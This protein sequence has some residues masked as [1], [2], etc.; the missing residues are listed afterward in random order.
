MGGISIVLTVAIFGSEQ[1][2][3]LRFLLPPTQQ[4]STRG[5]I[6]KWC[7]LSMT[8]ANLS[9]RD[10]KLVRAGVS[11][12][13]DNHCIAKFCGWDFDCPDRCHFWLRATSAT[14]FFSARSFTTCRCSSIFGGTLYCLF[15]LPYGLD[16]DSWRHG[17]VVVS[18][19]GQA[20]GPH[21]SAGAVLACSATTTDRCQAI[22]RPVV[23]TGPLA[24]CRL[25]GILEQSVA[26]GCYARDGL[27]RCALRGN[28]EVG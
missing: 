24:L 28:P 25:Q 19:G 22:A 7:S 3:R 4:K 20:S 26:P 13:L 12:V 2:Q 16:F 18:G 1:R 23:P 5:G 21:G 10:G 17:K 6:Q 8:N 11:S 9:S 15:Y 14:S 27:P